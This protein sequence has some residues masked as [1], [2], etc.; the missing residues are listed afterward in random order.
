MKP[1]N[2]YKLLTT[3]DF[4][5]E[6]K[7]YL[8]KELLNVFNRKVAYLSENPNHPSLNTKTLVISQQRLRQLGVDEVFEFR[9]N[10]GLRCIF[11]V[12]HTEKLIILA[13]IG[14]H[15]EVLRWFPK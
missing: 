5:K 6:I 8:P 2:S 3:P 14:N 13:K 10:K 7:K 9:I 1:D 15:D 11:Y 4:K 12:K